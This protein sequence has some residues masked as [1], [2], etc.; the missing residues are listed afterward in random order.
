MDDAGF[1]VHV[2]AGLKAETCGAFDVAFLNL[3]HSRPCDALLVGEAVARPDGGAHAVALLVGLFGQ[4]KHG[5]EAGEIV[6]GVKAGVGACE[7]A[8]GLVT[9][10]ADDVHAHVLRAERVEHVVD[11]GE[12]DGHCGS[13]PERAGRVAAAMRPARIP[14][15]CPL[16]YISNL[17]QEAV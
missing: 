1:D 3:L 8:A 9:G 2:D 14:G 5:C 11:V 10:E 16:I 17:E 12:S 4:V 15:W 7:I 13:P 6:V